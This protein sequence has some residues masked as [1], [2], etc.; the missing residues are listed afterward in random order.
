MQNV[1]KLTRYI[2]IP[3]ALDTDVVTENAE[4]S[5]IELSLINNKDSLKKIMVNSL[6]LA[7]EGVEINE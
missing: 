7:I 6:S 2:E 4:S 1:L 5:G 3:K